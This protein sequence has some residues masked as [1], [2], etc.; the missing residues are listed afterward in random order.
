M[1]SKT[2]VPIY[3]ACLSRVFTS[4]LGAFGAFLVLVDVSLNNWEIN[5]FLGNAQYFITPVA[6]LPTLHA[7]KSHYTFPNE[8]SP[9]DL[10]EVAEFMVNHSLATAIDHEGSHY[11][12]TAGSYAIHDAANDICGDLVHTY[13]LGNVTDSLLGTIRLAI[14]S[15]KLQY[16]RGN[17]FEHMSGSADTRPAPADATHAVL[18]DLGYKPTRMDCD[19]RLT[20]PIQVPEA[21]GVVVSTNTSMFRIFPKSLCTAC[22]PIVEFGHDICALNMT[23]N[24]TAQTI[25]VLS[26]K[27][28]IGGVHMV[29]LMFQ[30]TAASVASLVVRALC[31]VFAVFGYIASQKTIR[32]TDATALSTWYKR[33][34]Y[35]LSPPIYRYSSYAF[36]FSSFCLNSDWFVFGY[37][38]AVLLDEKQSMIYSKI[39]YTWNQHGDSSWISMQ[40][41]AI[42]FRW[43][44]LNCAIVKLFKVV[45]NFVSLT[46]YTGKNLLVGL[47]NFSSVF[48]IYL[49]AVVL[50]DRTNL[51]EGINHDMV[52]LSSST[53]P[54]DGL[55]VDVFDGYYIRTVPDILVVMTINLMVV[56]TIDHL[57]HLRWW[58]RVAKSSLGRQTM[59]NSTSILNEMRYDFYHVDGYKNQAVKIQARA[60]CTIQW[61]LMCHTMCFGLPEDPKHIR[62]L[63]SHA[64]KSDLLAVRR[65]SK[66]KGTSKPDLLKLNNSNR[67]T[68]YLAV[69]PKKSDDTDDAPPEDSIQIC[70]VVQDSDGNIRMYDSRR[71]ERVGLSVEVKILNNGKFI[72]G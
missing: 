51:I 37:M 1:I 66:S 71:S 38:T 70:I 32:W 35:T 60:L 25:T 11:L 12:L 57:V 47:C 41:F 22:T 31:V 61:F 52:S 3:F 72:L 33:A 68:K 65:P 4:C 36:S 26:S 64:A 27:A 6:N 10:S 7:I 23:Y 39:M 63:I 14:V 54:L 15:D 29:G 30:R 19:M 5:H 42:Q 9:E 34:I 24:A 67:S 45:L 62:A 16:V 69:R 28:L 2:M 53:E 56:L 58:R 17:L 20:T 13:P 49:G 40:I 46:R 43:L 44:W 18:T 21:S 8:A 55:R 48:Y 59:F 50:L